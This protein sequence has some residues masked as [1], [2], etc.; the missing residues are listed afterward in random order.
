MSRFQQRAG[1]HMIV[2]IPGPTLDPD[3]RAFLQKYRFKG[4][5]LFRRNVE[6]P[7]QLRTLMADLREVLGEEALIAIDQEGGAVIRIL[8]T[9][10]APSAMALG[11]TA[12]PELS[13]QVGA[14]VGRGL[15]SYG[16]NWNYAPSLDVNV[17]PFNP[18]IGDRSFGSDPESVALHGVNWA[19]G[20]EEA[21]VMASVKHFPGH[22]DTHIDTH[23]ALPTVNKP[24]EELL[25]TELHPF[26]KAAEAGVGSMMTAHIIFPALDSENP[27]TLSRNIL[28][29][30]L[31]DSWGYAGLIVTDAM[32][33]HAISRQYEG[34]QAAIKALNAGAD[35]ILCVN[36]LKLQEKQVEAIARAIEEG[37]LS[38]DLLSRSEEK[39]AHFSARFPCTP[40]PYPEEARQADEELM[41]TASR[42]ALTEYHIE[43]LPAPDTRILLLA[44]D[45]LSVGGAY[46]DTLSPEHL[47]ERLQ[48]VYS[49]VKL[50]TYTQ[51][52]PLKAL[53]EL[54]AAL[55]DAHHVVLGGLARELFNEQEL[56]LIS[57]IQS[58]GVPIL[59]LALWNPY[60]VMQLDLPAL[61]TYGFRH[62]AL[63]ALTETLQGKSPAGKLPVQF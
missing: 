7:E 56:Q 22:G 12:N 17:N 32:D 4:I 37:V 31:R 10:Q 8:D 63:Q 33:M 2:D 23:L 19:L 59:H 48:E 43:E 55:Q 21:G 44:P 18:M 53:P 34:G 38:E 39:L 28:T 49:E 54:F 30:L 45:K 1:Q 13:R 57:E 16:I 50:L 6:S 27:A 46:E 58:Q 61:I 14:A 26:K 36:D 11:A 5:C 35:L 15:R 42:Q 9:P 24:I 62:N 29:G 41:L 40:L 20:L 52:D 60:Q 3:T 25:K 51:Q 47:Q